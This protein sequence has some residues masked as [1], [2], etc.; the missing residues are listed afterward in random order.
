MSQMTDR[1]SPDESDWTTVE[2]VVR[3]SIAAEVRSRNNYNSGHPPLYSLRVGR[4]RIAPDASVWISPHMSIY[5]LEHAVELIDEL[6]EKYRGIR[7]SQTGR[8]IV[9]HR[10]PTKT[11]TSRDIRGYTEDTENE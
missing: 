7:L 1:E 9:E 6:G 10:R 8:R 4:A 11:S 2:T 3:G 5:D